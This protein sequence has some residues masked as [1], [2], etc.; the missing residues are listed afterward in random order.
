MICIFSRNAPKSKPFIFAPFSV[1]S[2]AFYSKCPTFAIVKFKWKT[3]GALLFRAKIGPLNKR[4]VTSFQAEKGPK[5][6]DFDF[7]AFQLKMQITWSS[8]IC[9]AFHITS[10]YVTLSFV[11]NPNSIFLED[12]WTTSNS[13]WH[14]NL[15]ES[16][17]KNLFII[18]SSPSALLWRGYKN[19]YFVFRLCNFFPKILERFS[20][21]FQ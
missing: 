8:S 20:S 12:D 15:S 18:R 19:L 11:N 5:M 17:S 6:R 1:W 9:R 16:S 7:G 13:A 3:W 4:H 14:A 10:P 2:R 21:F